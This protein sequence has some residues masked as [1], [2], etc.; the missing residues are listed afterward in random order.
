M[1]IGDIKD[2]LWDWIN[3]ATGLD[4]SF[5]NQPGPDG[6]ASAPR[7]DGYPWATL[8]I[9]SG[10]R[11]IGKR[12]ILGP[13]PG[14]SSV[15]FRSTKQKEIVVTLTMSGEDV[16]DLVDQAVDYFDK[17]EINGDLSRVQS[18][19][20]TI[21]TVENDSS[22]TLAINGEPIT[23]VSGNPATDLDIR[24]AFVTAIPL[25]VPGVQAV[26]GASDAELKIIGKRRGYEYDLYIGTPGNPPTPDSKM[27]LTEH[28]G[29]VDLV[30]LRDTGITDTSELLDDTTW[31][32]R[33]VNDIT[34]GTSSTIT[35]EPGVIEKVE[36]T[37]GI[38]NETFITE[39]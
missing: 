18:D 20:V 22:Y 38:T 24:D 23:V 21:V 31:E 3:A 35:D 30:Y 33:K 32:P 26:A 12:D 15:M 13:K 37:D 14:G 28:I 34:F 4:A 1:K 16:A 27:E 6:T 8:E 5:V 25:T 2:V 29:A 19:T 11:N 17:Q 10:P 39:A 7:P 36:I 9:I